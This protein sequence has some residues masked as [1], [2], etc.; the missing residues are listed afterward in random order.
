[1]PGPSNDFPSDMRGMS[2]LGRTRWFLLALAGCVVGALLWLQITKAQKPQTN[3]Q[4]FEKAVA[5]GASSSS[6][7]A[8]DRLAERS[9]Q[10]SSRSS[11]VPLVG[12]PRY[13]G[14]LGQMVPGNRGPKGDPRNVMFTGMQSVPDDDLDRLDGQTDLHTLCFLAVPLKDVQMEHLKHWRQ[15][16]RLQ[17]CR[18]GITDAGLKWIADLGELTSLDI[19]ASQEQMEITDKGTV[20]IGT[21]TKLETLELKS[22]RITDA[23]LA[24]LKSLTRLKELCLNAA[25]LTGAGLERLKGATH[26][27]VLDL[28]ATKTNDE[29]LQNIKWFPDLTRLELFGTQVTDAGVRH[30]K[31]LAELRDLGLMYTNVSDAALEDIA[32]LGKLRRV[33]LEG[34]KVTAKG[35]KKLRKALPR[36]VVVWP[37]S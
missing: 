16:K 18:T 10:R 8:A 22:T 29:G 24:Q 2:C 11:V 23:G 30:I 25:P 36:C 28:F 5:S 6:S 32:S 7:D 35:V 4:E 15:L 20:H 26:L 14:L 21:L 3:A 17:L 31:G 37:Y 1:M 12:P 34:T 27:T 13:Q 19:E 33:Q 9:D